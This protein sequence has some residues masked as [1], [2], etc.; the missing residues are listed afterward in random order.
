M[1][2]EAD[3]LDMHFLQLVYSLHAAAMQQMGKTMSPMTG[4]VE[5]SLEM[6]RNSID[7]LDMIKRKTDG[8]LTGEEQQMIDRF[9]YELRMNYVEE[10]KKGP[11]SREETPEDN[12]KA[13]ENEAAEGSEK[14]E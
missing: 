11:D 2:E 4:K 6:A 3:K 1:T 9:L 5:R 10:M 12:E 8:N 7:M 14:S 13:P